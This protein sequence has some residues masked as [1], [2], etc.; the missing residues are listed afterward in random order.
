MMV[1]NCVPVKANIGARL[2][3]F[4]ERLREERQRLGMSQAEFGAA[5]GVLK[6][7]QLKYEKGERTP[8]AA[9]LAA[10]AQAG[11]D[12]QYLL[13]GSRAF[14]PPPPI[15][16]E[17]RALIRDYDASSDDGRDAIRR[18]AAA[19]ALGAAAA[20]AGHRAPEGGKQ[21]PPKK[22]DFSIQADKLGAVVKRAAKRIT[23]NMGDKKK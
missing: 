10:I 16:P 20:V 22:A 12:V 6:Q 13:T 4:G 2:D 14:T 19:T 23:I 5:G 21:A 18:M 7:A 9:Y 17:H 3:N 8:D 1:R 15:S 11:A